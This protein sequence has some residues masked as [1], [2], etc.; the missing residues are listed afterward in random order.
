MRSL[1]IKY[2]TIGLLMVIAA[3]TAVMLKPDKRMSEQYSHF[4]LEELIPESFGDW[5]IDK[6]IVPLQ[7]DPEK[8]EVIKQTYSQV[9]SRTYYNAEGDRIMISVAYGGDQSDT[10]QVHKPEACYPAQGFTIYNDKENKLDTGFG[11][12]P[13]KNLLAVQGIRN[14]PI[15]YWITIGEKIALDGINWKLTRIKYG[16]TGTVPD[17]LLFR[18][19]S[20]GD[21][22]RGYQLQQKF[23]RDLLKSVP[24]KSRLRLMGNP[25]Y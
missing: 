4:S 19:S 21:E 7:V 6:N 18:V 22:Q 8:L 16:L 1:D 3:I 10:M 25:T 15:T 23:I 12:I 5:K 17:G 24:E 11:T 9:L 2:F 14:E 20:I 13:V